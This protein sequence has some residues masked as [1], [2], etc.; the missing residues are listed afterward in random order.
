MFV[1]SMETFLDQEL[2]LSHITTH[3]LVILVGV[4]LFKKA[5]RFMFSNQ[6]MMKFGR[7]VL[8]VNVHDVLSRRKVLPS[9]DCI[10]SVCLM[11][12]CQLPANTSVYSS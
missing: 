10:C 2:S 9:A 8:Q 5:C 1:S 4:T 7:I 3:H 6:I 11:H 12:V